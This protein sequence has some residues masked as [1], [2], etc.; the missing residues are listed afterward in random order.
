MMK[1]LKFGLD[2]GLAFLKSNALKRKSSSPSL[3][4]GDKE[5]AGWREI[6]S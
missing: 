6:D 4:T 5:L 2:A 1:W 3:E